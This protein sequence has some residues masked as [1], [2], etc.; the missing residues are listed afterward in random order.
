MQKMDG[1]TD[2]KPDGHRVMTLK[3]DLL[4]ISQS[5]MK[6]YSSIYQSKKESAK[7]CVFPVF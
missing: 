7:N 5:L 1:W 6:N 4:Y 2:R 3:L